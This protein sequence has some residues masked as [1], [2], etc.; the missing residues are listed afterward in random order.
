MYLA[1]FALKEPPFSIT[2]DPRFLYMSERH[3]EALAHLLYGIGEGGGFIQLTGE[4]GTGK[5]CVCRCLLEQL[6][7]HVDVAL[8]LNPRL[9]AL[10]LLATICDELRV[11]YERGTGSSK[12]LVDVLYRHL[13][14]AH[15]A[16]R[17]TVVIL[18]EAQDLAPDVL[19]E[20]RLLTNL[21]TS[22]EKLLQIILIGQPELIR[23]LAQPGLR[24]VDQRVTARYHLQPLSRAET[25]AY[26][27]HRMAVAGRS[28]RVF[29]DSAVRVVYRLSGGIPRLINVICDRALLGAYTQDRG[30]V[31]AGTARRAAA[32]VLGRRS[33]WPSGRPRRRIAAGL[34]VLGAAAALVLFLPGEANRRGVGVDQEGAAATAPAGAA[35]PPPARPDPPIPSVRPRAIRSDAAAGAPPRLADLL[36]DASRA[37][38]LRDAFGSLFARWEV[39]PLDGGELTGCE[40][41]RAHGL[42][43]LFLTGSWAKLRR[44]GL[45]AIIELAER[46]GDKRYVTL[47]ALDG[48][49]A[50]LRLGP[51][52]VRLPFR[53]IDPFWEGASIVLWRPPPVPLP[54]TPGTRGKAPEWLSGRLAEIDGDPGPGA[55][56]EVYGDALLRRVVAFQRARSLP[57]DGVVGVE[58]AISLAAAA[59]DPGWPWFGSP[60]R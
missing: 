41:A 39:P 55:P 23:L 45:P 48:D 20:V 49:H 51:R 10:E 18:D 59:R 27:R 36:T 34:L 26:V 6:P 22:R 46:G 31:D 24:Q 38:T 17:R 25:H 8:V 19:E 40:H 47:V 28:D 37:G 43:C 33:G 4:V 29:T 52:E 35:A 3:Q 11:T 2:P 50:T 1:H 32:E 60:S 21:E 16:G 54:V 12:A 44:V 15:A 42:G 7:P 5:T 56:G 58:T 57:A 53:E 14:E 9:S 30:R 13:L